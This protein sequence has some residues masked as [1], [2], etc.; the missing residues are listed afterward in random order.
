MAQQQPTS[1]D[2]VARRSSHWALRSLGVV[3]GSAV[4]IGG[5]MAVLE[6]TPLRP[7]HALMLLGFL[8]TGLLFVRFGLTGRQDVPS[9]RPKIAVWVLAAAGCLFIGTGLYTVLLDDSA[10]QLGKVVLTVFIVVGLALCLHA[11]KLWKYSRV[12]RAE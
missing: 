12:E 7:R 8:A 6:E 10:E 1:D 3:L 9:L 2:T 11:I 4:I 5:M